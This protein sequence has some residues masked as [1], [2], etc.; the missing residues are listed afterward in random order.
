SSRSSGSVCSRPSSI[1]SVML[2]SSLIRPHFASSAYAQTRS[3]FPSATWRRASWTSMRG[4]SDMTA[5][6]PVRWRASG[7][8]EDSVVHR[9]DAGCRPGG[10]LR[11][12]LLGPGAH[13]SLQD[14]LAALHFD[15]D[16]L[17][18]EL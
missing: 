14:D 1:D 5:S 13:G 4:T 3:A 10:P 11:L 2:P 6:I 9:G 18:V 17:G 8:D 7:L 12:F 15:G 16:P